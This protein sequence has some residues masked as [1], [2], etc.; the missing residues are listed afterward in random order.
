MMNSLLNTL[1]AA[2]QQAAQTTAT[3]RQGVVTSYDPDAYAI[4]VMLQPDNTLTGWLSLKSPWV[5]NGWGLFC[6]PSIGDLVEIDYQ[7]GA[8]AAGSVGWRFYNDEDKPL[9]CPSGEFW[10]VHRSGSL[11]KFHND[12][13]VELVTAGDLR[14]TVK[15]DYHLT[16]EGNATTEVKGT[17]TTTAQAIDLNG[18]IGLNGPISQ[19]VAEGADAKALLIGPLTVKEGA[20]VKGIQVETHDHEVKGIKAGGDTV[21]SEGPE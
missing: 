11:L 9:P 2:S 1:R 8:A 16:V 13:G 5:G 12:G 18:E 21:K 10:L 15:G 3:T 7:E 14:E 4:R 20:T 6:P 19:T 17:Q